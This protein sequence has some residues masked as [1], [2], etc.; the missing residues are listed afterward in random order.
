MAIPYKGGASNVRNSRRRRAVDFSEI[1]DLKARHW[2]LTKRWRRA[3]RQRLRPE[4]SPPPGSGTTRIVAQ[5][6]EIELG[7]KDIASAPW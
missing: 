4:L 5:I 1:A 2:A 7:L 3:Q 6:R